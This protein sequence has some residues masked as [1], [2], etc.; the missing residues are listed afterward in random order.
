[1]PEDNFKNKAPSL[2]CQTTQ[3]TGAPQVTSDQ[4]GFETYSTRRLGKLRKTSSSG[5]SGTF[6]HSDER[7]I[8]TK[9]GQEIG[10][11]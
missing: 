11:A 2:H 1:M 8:A 5:S 10:G 9:C 3:V 6:G 4:A 7:E